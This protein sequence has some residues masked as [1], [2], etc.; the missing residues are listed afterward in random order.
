MNKCQFCKKEF[1]TAKTL[2]AHMCPKKKRWADK[3]TIGARLGFRVYQQFYTM[4]TQSKKPK[5]QEVFI[6]DRMYTAFVKYGRHLAD[7]NPIDADKF[8]EYVIR[9]GIPIDKWCFDSTYNAYLKEHIA[10]ELAERA[11]ERTVLEMQRWATENELT[12]QDFFGSVNTFEAVQLVR[13][14]RI[15]P[16]LLYLAP[17]SDLLWDR[18]SEEQ[19]KLISEAVDPEIWQSKFSRQIGDVVFVKNIAKSSGL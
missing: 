1:T 5:T 16:W 17:S 14:G 3:N 7:L 11:F 6:Q 15:S 12:L 18:F 10:K 4:T 2:S 19:E 13:S 8:I 9:N